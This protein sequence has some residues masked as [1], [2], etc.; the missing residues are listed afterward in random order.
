MKN[1]HYYVFLNNKI[2]VT[3][4][5]AL[6]KFSGFNGRWQWQVSGYGHD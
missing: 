3:L 6:F 1:Q 5:W 2:S 4:T